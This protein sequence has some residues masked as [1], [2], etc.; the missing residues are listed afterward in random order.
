MIVFRQ[1]APRK[2]RLS[3]MLAP[4]SDSNKTC[5]WLYYLWARKLFSN[6]TF[7]SSM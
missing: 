4:H 1:L 7:Y 6:P 2:R 5:L 3:D